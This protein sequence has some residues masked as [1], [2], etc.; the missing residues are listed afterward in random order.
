[1]H[2]AALAALGRTDFTYQHLPVPP[3]LLAETVRALPAAGFVGAN[4][5][6]PHKEAVLALATTATARARAIGAA[7]TLSFD[8]GTGAVHA[9]NTDAPGVIAALP[10]PPRGARALILGAGGSA[11]AVAWALRDAGAREVLVWNRN[12][13]RAE[14]L[15]ADLGVTATRTAAPA[16]VLIN[17]TPAGLAG[18]PPQFKDWPLDADHLSS[19]PC[20]VD[21]VYVSEGTTHL[22]SA[23]AQ[24]GCT[25]VDGL[26]ILVRQGAESFS[27]WTG[28]EAPLQAMR[29][30][31]ARGRPARAH[32]PAPAPEVRDRAGERR[33]AGP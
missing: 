20:V 12:P 31:A 2:R 19:Y 11:R 26:E 16:D 32:E 18:Q 3:E 13:E 8:P 4:V 27:A 1:M 24:S 9:D 23:A 10:V 15:A 17:C 5:T 7:N 30:G 14:V 25:V 22:V 21:L 28:L 33:G 6:I 29:Q